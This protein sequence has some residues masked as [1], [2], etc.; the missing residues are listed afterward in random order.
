MSGLEEGSS[1]G[2]EECVGSEAM[3]GCE[4]K[5]ECG[6]DCGSVV[7]DDSHVCP[8]FSTR[9][10]WVFF[11]TAEKRYLNWDVMADVCERP[12]HPKLAFEMPLKML[13]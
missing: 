5:E 6:N 8:A 10:Q 11:T 7:T 9:I 4:V 13:P 12:L 1:S 2:V 3:E